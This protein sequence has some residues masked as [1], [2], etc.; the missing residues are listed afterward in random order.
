MLPTHQVEG[1]RIRCLRHGVTF[2]RISSCAA[3]DAEPGEAIAAGHDAPLP[4][5]PA[6]CVSSV[7]LER[8]VAAELEVIRSA[9]R[10]LGARAPC[11]APLVKRGKAKNR[12]PPKPDRV[13]LSTA[14]KLW[15]TWLKGVR[16]LAH[17]VA[18]REDAELVRQRERIDAERARGASH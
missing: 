6:G 14:A 5:A 8:Q 18:A 2:D 16:V 7:E 10:D 4:P 3:C 9:A 13:K 11:S 12:K 17:L 1:E 15:D